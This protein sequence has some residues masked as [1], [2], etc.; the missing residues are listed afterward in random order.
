MTKQTD[1]RTA[2]LRRCYLFDGASDR[3]L[4]RLA[5]EASEETARTGQAL[6]A[7]GDEA[8]G[9]RIVTAGLVRVWIN[10]ADGKELTLTLLEPGD[11]LGEI[12]LLDGMPR[13]ANATAQ[14]VSRLLVLRRSSFQRVLGEEPALAL[15]LVTLLCERL[16]RATGDIES[17]A[18]LDLR[19]RL[20]RK[21][22]DL[23]IAHATID[24]NRA[25]F[26]RKFSQMEIAQMLGVTREAVNKQLAALSGDGT[27]RIVAGRIEID[28][29]AALTR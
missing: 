9:L 22:H 25:R 27:V 15:H 3:A 6:F 2:L 28:D 23:A 21:L 5:T 24:G 29:L 11:A 13:S 7:V 14:E 12:A 8:D 4:A 18:F 26:T 10:D 16:R 17:L 1:D 19:H 20:A